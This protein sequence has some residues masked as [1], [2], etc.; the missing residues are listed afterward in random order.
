MGRFGGKARNMNKFV[1]LA[2]AAVVFSGIASAQNV[3]AVDVFGGYSYLNFKVPEATGFSNAQDLKLNGWDASAA[4]ALFH[5]LSAEADFSGH[6]LTDCGGVSGLKCDNFSYMFGPRYTFG[7]RGSR[8]TFFVHGLVGRDQADFVDSS[9]TDTAINDTSISVAAGGGL[10]LWFMRHVGVQ[11][12]PI[13]F[14]YANHLNEDG[15][16]RQ[17]TYRAAGGIV[18]R[19]GGNFPAKEE[20]AP[21]PPKE[22]EAKKEKEKSEGHRSWKRPW[23]KDTTAKSSQPEGSNQP[24][25]VTS[26]PPEPRESKPRQSAPSSPTELRPLSRGMPVRTL[27]ITVAPQEFDGARVLEIE[28]GSIAEMASLHVG[29]MI[30]S[31]DGKAVRTPMELAAELSDKSGKVRI[32]FTR[33]GVLNETVI[34][35]GK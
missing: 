19:F 21:K 35:L 20:K 6:Q 13:D 15:A 4:I 24:V 14:V 16:P 1:G 18:F 28:P 9:G 34:L 2:L 8:F 3:P 26:A 5:H 22:E 17:T 32:G 27:G 12:G 31:V 29:D 23:H 33:G 10:D 25:P 11:V 7:D 30:K